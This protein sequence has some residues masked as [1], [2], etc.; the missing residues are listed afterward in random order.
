LSRQRKITTKRQVELNAI[1]QAVAAHLNQGATGI[2]GTSLSFQHGYEG[3]K[4]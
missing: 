2:K 4:T 1:L 3:N